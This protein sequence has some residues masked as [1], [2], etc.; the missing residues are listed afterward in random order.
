MTPADYLDEFLVEFR[1]QL[2]A[3]ERRWGDTWLK[4]PKKGQADRIFERI[5]EY[6]QDEFLAQ[7][8][9]HGTDQPIFIDS[10]PWMKITGEALIGWIRE[11]Y[12]NEFPDH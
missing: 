7:T 6:Y 11:R 8:L 5:R 3:D 2:A 4:R 1:A 12:P 9:N 10:L